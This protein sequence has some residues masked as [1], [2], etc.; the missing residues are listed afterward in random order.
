MRVGVIGLGKMGKPM[1]RNLLK[2]GFTVVVHNRSRG[3]VDELAREGAVAAWSP[4]EVAQQADVVVTSLPTPASVEE[5]YLG[6]HGLIGAARSGQVL[7]DT[8]TVSPGLSRRLYEAAKERGAGFLD[9]P[10]SGGPA[11]AESATLTIMVGGD[12]EVV[13]QA[14][15][16]FQALGK[17]IHHVGPSGAGSVVKLVNQLLVAIN[18]AGV[19]EAIVFGVKAGA[20]PQVLLDV[21]KTSFGGSRM[22]E[23]ALPLVM[24]RQ[25]Q[26][27]TPVNLILKDLGLIH[28]VGKELDT[29]LLLGA[30]AQEVFKEARAAGFGEEDMVALFKPVE[31]LAGV[32]VRGHGTRTA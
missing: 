6:E 22:L 21:I 25:F 19:A 2:A 23:R 3:P 10:V 14:M 20:D 1:T 7:I 30:L 5:V 29:R 31:R 11:G 17:N 27:G 8:S 4:A 15:P 32:E 28:E 16:V 12:A 9:A 24:E 13:E 18:M 26:P